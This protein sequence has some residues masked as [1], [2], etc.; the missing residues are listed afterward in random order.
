MTQRHIFFAEIHRAESFTKIFAENQQIL[1]ICSVKF[2]D[3]QQSF[4]EI[5]QMLPKV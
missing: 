5:Q 3:H 1:L 4:A 2:T